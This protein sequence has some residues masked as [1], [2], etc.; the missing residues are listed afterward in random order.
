M[1]AFSEPDWNELKDEWESNNYFNDSLEGFQAHQEKRE[2]KMI[3]Y[4]TEYWFDI[5]SFF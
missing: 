5:T 3:S 1:T 2:S 4:K